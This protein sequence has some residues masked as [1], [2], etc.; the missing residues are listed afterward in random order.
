MKKT[1]YILGITLLV[2]VL[3]GIFIF[4]KVYNKPHDNLSKTTPDF[5]LSVEQIVSDFEKNENQANKKYLDKIVQVEGIITEINAVNG[6]SVVTIASDN[7]SKNI[8][9]N[10]DVVE[11]KKVLALQEGQKIALRGVCAGYLMDVIL[12]RT[13]IV[14]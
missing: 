5:V 14:N 10:M 9:C 6:N 4:M 2:A 8:V 1:L 11:N 3:A 7:H 12:V 13:I